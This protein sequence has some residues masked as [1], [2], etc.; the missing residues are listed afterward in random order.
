MTDID[1]EWLKLR[2]EEAAK[3]AFRE[4]CEKHG[5][6]QICAF[7]L[8]YNYGDMKIHAATNTVRHLEETG[9]NDAEN[10]YRPEKWKYNKEGAGNLFRKISDVCAEYVG[11]LSWAGYPT[12]RFEAEITWFWKKVFTICI[13]VLE[14]MKNEGFFRK[15]AGADILLVFNRDEHFVMEDVRKIVSRLNENP[16]RDEY[17]EWREKNS[18][19]QL[20]NFLMRLQN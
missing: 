18:N 12:E 19:E 20:K 1:F 13:E 2:M 9:I 14:K 7:A 17:L 10:R 5:E 16:F 3:I 4:L 8:C 6:E 11:S 15:H